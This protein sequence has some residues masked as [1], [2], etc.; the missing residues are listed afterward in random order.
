MFELQPADIL[1]HQKINLSRPARLRYCELAA[2]VAAV[3]ASVEGGRA[4]VDSWQRHRRPA[5]SGVI[6]DIENLA[7]FQLTGPARG[8]KPPLEVRQ[9]IGRLVS[10]AMVLRGYQGIGEKG[11]VGPHS[12]WFTRAEV[13]RAAA[14]WQSETA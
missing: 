14:E 3:L 4:M 1:N 2:D 7:S 13:F 6:V 10:A 8:I 11:A 5:L 9:L 12:Q